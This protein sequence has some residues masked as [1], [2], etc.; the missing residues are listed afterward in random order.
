M[1]MQT[2]TVNVNGE[3]YERSV[4]PRLL[5]SD[6]IRHELSLT[7]THVG[8]EHGICGACTVLIEGL[9]TRSCLYFAVQA[10]GLSIETVE[11]LGRV[12]A[13]HPI[14]QAFWEKHGLQCGFC[15][16]GMLMSAVELLRANPN[17]D[18]DAIVEAIGGNLCR[19]TGY[20]NIIAAVERAAELQRAAA[21]KEAA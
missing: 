19:C 7:G 8:C 6:F 11:S 1:T 3:S 2:I 21:Q 10:D 4:E 18:R 14:Q 20:Q 5:L 16:P 17:P 12:D 9:S 15:T 13:L